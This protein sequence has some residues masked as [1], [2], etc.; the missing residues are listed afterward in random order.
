[1]LTCKAATHLMSEA[2]DRPLTLGE[3]CRLYWHLL[4]CIGCR[5][6]RR[7]MRFIRRASRAYRD[8]HE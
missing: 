7:Q 3:R 8:H 5:A 6:F 1:M 2:L 4:A